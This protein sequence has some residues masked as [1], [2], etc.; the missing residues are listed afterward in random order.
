MRRPNRYLDT[1]SVTQW[2]MQVAFAS[3]DYHHVDQHFGASTRLVVYGVK[4][5]QVQ[6]LRVAEFSAESGHQQEKI[7]C[8]MAALEDCVTLYCLAIGDSVFR[9]LLEIGVRA[10]KVPQDTDIAHL[11]KQTQQ[12]WSA[13]ERQV[14]RHRRDPGRFDKLLAGDEWQE[15]DRP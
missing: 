3:S 4:Q 9:Q 5:D 7:A 8:R 15:E 11:L 10:I 14:T 6:L 13:A 12:H 2:P 1:V